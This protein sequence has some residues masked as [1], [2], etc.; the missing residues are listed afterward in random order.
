MYFTNK[1]HMHEKQ[2]LLNQHRLLSTK[3]ALYKFQWALLKN[4]EMAS[5]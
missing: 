3:N 4:K 1:V 2:Q 5:T